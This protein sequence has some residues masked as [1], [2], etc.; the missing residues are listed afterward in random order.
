MMSLKL[1]MPRVSGRGE[2]I[3][4]SSEHS[5]TDSQIING[6]TPDWR[7]LQQP[8]FKMWLD[9]VNHR[10]YVSFHFLK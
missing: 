1:Q 6:Q 5:S 9:R 2:C 4:C 7:T 10:A 8:H 3:I